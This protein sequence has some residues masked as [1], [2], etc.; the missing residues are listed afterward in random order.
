MGP[1][2]LQT[3]RVGDEL[4]SNLEPDL[5]KFNEPEEVVSILF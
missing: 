1:V 5:I 2:W 4:N 3:C